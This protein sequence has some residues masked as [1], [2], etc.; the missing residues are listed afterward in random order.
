MCAQS[1]DSHRRAPGRWLW[2]GAW[3]EARA[4]VCKGCA[5]SGYAQRQQR[6]LCLLHSVLWAVHKGGAN[7]PCSFPGGHTSAWGVRG[8]Q[9]AFVGVRACGSG[10]TRTRACVPGGA[11]AGAERAV[12]EQHRQQPHRAAERSGAEQVGPPRYRVCHR[13][14]GR[15]QGRAVREPDRCL[16]RAEQR[17]ERLPGPDSP[18]RGRA[19]RRRRGAPR[20]PD[21]G[22]AQEGCRGAGGLLR[23]RAEPLRLPSKWALPC[24]QQSR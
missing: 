15:A 20:L 22:W 7:A 1:M 8:C 4:Q 3:M 2:M 24:P 21:P 12:P 6:G 5:C 17:K 14:R 16:L 9:D 18:S 19:C 11:G 10:G 13:E 23:S